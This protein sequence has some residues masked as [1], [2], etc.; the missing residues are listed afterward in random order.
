MPPTR[1]KPVIPASERPQAHVL[2]FADRKNYP[3]TISEDFT[4]L[5]TDI[6]VVCRATVQSGR[7]KI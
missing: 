7:E 2:N 4:E 5:K 3:S 1:V 6:A